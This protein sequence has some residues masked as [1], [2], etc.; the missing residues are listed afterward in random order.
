MWDRTLRLQLH[1]IVYSILVQPFL[2]WISNSS[3]S[4][5]ASAYE[6]EV[7]EYGEFYTDAAGNMD[8]PP[9]YT[10]TLGELGK[11]IMCHKA[12]KKHATLC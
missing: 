6:A 1:A 5:V 4:A 3:D 12:Y 7:E 2:Y 10:R 8:V 9:P 11:V